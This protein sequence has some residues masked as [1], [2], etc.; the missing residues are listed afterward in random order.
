VFTAIAVIIVINRRKALV[1]VR[2]FEEA[3]L[4]QKVDEAL[5][6]T[7]LLI[8]FVNFHFAPSAATRRFLFLR[9]SHR[10]SIGRHVLLLPLLFYSVAVDLISGSAFVCISV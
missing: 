3:A 9:I 6:F 8:G 10:K 4:D 7:A 5:E 2:R 1:C